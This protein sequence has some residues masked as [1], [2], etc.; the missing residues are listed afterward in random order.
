MNEPDWKS[1]AMY[2]ADC[3]AATGEHEALMSRTSRSSARRMRD[4]CATAA[5]MA[6]GE[7]LARA[8]PDRGVLDR[9]DNAVRLIDQKWSGPP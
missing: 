7:R 6:R 1:I 9:L 2:L 3:H 5:Q 4:I 8:R